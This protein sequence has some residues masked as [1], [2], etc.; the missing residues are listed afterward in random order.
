MAETILVVADQTSLRQLLVEYLM[1]Q[2]Y[3]VVTASDGPS[4]LY[5]ARHEHPDLILLDLTMAGMDGHQFLRDVRQEHSVPVIIITEREDETGTVPGMEPGVD[6]YVIRPFRM[7]DLLARIRAVLRRGGDGA[8]KNA[9]LRAGK[10]TLNLA[11]HTVTVGDRPVTLTPIEF[12]LLAVLMRAQ[13][14]T[15]TRADIARQLANGTFSGSSRTLNVH[16]CNLR[17]KIEDDPAHPQIIETIYGI[18]Y[19]FCMP[20]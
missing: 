13:G 15:L 11:A 6:D 8:E 18:G 2:G 1:K 3:R 10:I 17:D 12:D 14:H 9:V 16:I 20:P 7:R 4:A 5:T 19:R